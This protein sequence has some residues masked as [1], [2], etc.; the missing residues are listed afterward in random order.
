MNSFLRRLH[1]GFRRGFDTGGVLH[2]VAGF[3]I[4]LTERNP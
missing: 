2:D 3:L 4:R 1:P